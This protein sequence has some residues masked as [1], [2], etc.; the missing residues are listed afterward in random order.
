MSSEPLSFP[1]SPPV[2]NIVE[3]YNNNELNTQLSTDVEI[4]LAWF[5]NYDL[6]PL[7]DTLDEFRINLPRIVTSP[8]TAVT[9]VALQQK[10]NIANYNYYPGNSGGQTG[11]SLTNNYGVITSEQYELLYKGVLFPGQPNSNNIKNE[12]NLLNRYPRM[13]NG[14]LGSHS[15]IQDITLAYQQINNNR[16]P[17]AAELLT[18]Y[19]ECGKWNNFA[20]FPY[21]SAPTVRQVEDFLMQTQKIV[22]AESTV[23][24]SA[25]SSTTAGSSDYQNFAVI[26]GYF[27]V[28]VKSAILPGKKI[29]YKIPRPI[30]LEGYNYY[31]YTDI[32]G[33]TERSTAIDGSY[34]LPSLA[35]DTSMGYWLD[36][37]KVTDDVDESSASSSINGIQQQNQA[38][39]IIRPSEPTL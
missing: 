30:V 27:E 39:S 3:L 36:I 18:L 32:D 24:L 33:S 28:H 2:K 12:L 1:S 23:S 11:Y 31:T 22:P 5:A 35:L 19:N 38:T 17:S 9:D 7:N 15:M 25:G 21:C 34:I 29:V 4:P 10:L 26:D 8:N 20:K 16:F 13:V 37:P 14:L 6:D